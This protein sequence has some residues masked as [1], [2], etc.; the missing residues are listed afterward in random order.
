MRL[1]SF[2]TYGFKSFAEKTE[3]KFDK[4]ITA[5]VGPNGSGKSNIS[6]AI[7]W[8]LGEQSAKYLR[9]SKMEDV[10]FSGSSKRRALGVAEVTVDFDN[11]DGTLPLDFEQVSITRRLFRSGDSDYA[12]NKKNC[13]LRD[14][15]DLLADTGLGKGSMSIISQNKIDE[16]LN[17]RPEER[18][19]IFE[20]AAGIAKYRLRKKDALKRLDDTA[21]NLTRISD[22]RSEVDA[23]VEPLAQAAAKTQ[24]FNAFSEEL[25]LCRLTVLLHKLDNMQSINN[26]LLAQKDEAANE[27]AQQAAAYSRKQAELA[28]IQRDLDKL[29]E[30][31]TKLQDAIK[32]KETTLEK[33]RGQQDVLTER[34]IQSEK[35]GVRLDERDKKL[36]EQAAERECQMQSLADEFDT[37]DKER[38]KAQLLTEKLQGERD[39]E[40]RRLQDAKEQNTAAQSDFFADMQTLLKLRNELHQLEQE[41]EQ[42]VRRRD[43]LKKSIVEVEEAQEKS[44]EQYNG[45][46]EKQARNAHELEL[47]EKNYHENKQAKT[48]VQKRI[49]EITTLQQECQRRL[50]EVETAEQSLTRLQV[51]YDGFGFGD[52]VVLKAQ[53]PWKEQVCG[54]VAEL[55]SVE[56]KYVAAIETALGD[57]AQNIVTADVATAKQAI[58]YLKGKGG[59]ATFLPLDNLQ[60]KKL[61]D[62]EVLLKALPGVCGYAI[63][64]VSCDKH[65]DK[66]IRFLLGTILVAENMD[67][68]LAAAKA[69]NFRI[70]VVT[71]A[72]DV[73]NVGG[74]LTGGSRKHKEGYLTRNIEIKQARKKLKELH[75]EMLGLQEQLEEQEDNAKKLR[76]QEQSLNEEL[77]QLRLRG[78]ELKMLLEQTE[79]EKL[80]V[81]E[82]LALLLS[83][84]K[85]VTNEYLGNRDKLKNLREQV[86][87]YETKDASAKVQLEE[88]NKQI[89]QYGS[90][91]TALD[92]KLQDAKV[93]LETS[94]AKV[95]YI[96][97][98]MQGLDYDTLQ[99]RDEIAA[100][101]AEKQRL[102]KTITACQ[103]QKIQL[104]E[105][106]ETVLLALRK[107]MS[108]KDDFADKRSSLLNKQYDMQQEGAS[109]KRKSADSESVLRQLELDLTRHNSDYNH[110]KEQLA[111]EYQLQEDEARRIDLSAWQGKPIEE[112]QKAER[113]LTVKISD[114]GPINAAAIEE[115]QAVKE[116]S[117]FLRKQYDDLCIA[118]ENLETVISD[119]NSGM[120][121]RFQ[122]AFAKINEYFAQCY[123]KLF[124][125]GTAV[126]KLTEPENILDSGIDIEVQP[127]GKKLQSLYLL[128]GGER[129]LTVIALL[130]ALLSYLPS[131]FCVLDEIDA[132]L[133][134]A[135][136]QRFANFL[137]E[138]AADT[139][140]IIITHRKGTMEAA[141]VMYGVTMEE[142]GVSTL[143][144]VKIN[145]KE[146]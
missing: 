132:A 47:L 12:I 77:Q 93:L 72:G 125:G 138:Y 1:K 65:V 102:Q 30:S 44:E 7:R 52:R 26:K 23:Q 64:L 18:R 73:V 137:R 5:V 143:L 51:A 9:G 87:E 70:R 58:K 124:G 123:I 86:S 39:I 99:I 117:E 129:A 140:F 107:I 69:S 78:S 113:N 45:L 82:K 79:Q 90:N 139:Q 10:I 29:A 135:N 105:E 75:Q 126:L 76:Q 14:I 2:S 33:L 133:D 20:E 53:E 92:N 13:R 57:G 104:K 106:E 60:I 15:I 16:I 35:A 24:Q 131:P 4:G 119:I 28:A 63:D 42:R 71:L 103:E 32:N 95:Q 91:V 146:S 98:R 144:S 34:I 96:N 94:T 48:D 55:I 22:I 68:A 59:R 142:S 128:S 120:V 141:D 134:D 83:D 8:V 56:D 89:A 81:G 108:G 66:A 116:R 130:F 145:A 67:A 122:E 136:I 41:Q 109:L 115:Y 49:N 17:S 110:A 121:E 11:T 43:A 62:N 27:F 101:D 127:P 88:L 84:R 85:D 37:V 21:V 54:V 50:T 112:L 46:L 6:D 25:R 74:S 80:R 61:K 100:N 31:Y 114:L 3:I 36:E 111:E 19:S 118:K 97:E 38:I 40:N